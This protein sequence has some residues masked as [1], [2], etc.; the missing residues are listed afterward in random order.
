M[1][2]GTPRLPG[3]G[4][5]R[6]PA[7]AA[8]GHDPAQPPPRPRQQLDLDE[9]LEAAIAIADADGLAAVSTRAVAARFDKTAMAL[10]PYVGT[11]EN[12]LAL[13]RDHASAMPAWEDPGTEPGRRAAGLGAGAVRGVPGPPVARPNGHGHRRARARTSRTGSNG[14]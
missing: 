5:A 11:K 3:R 8:P 14:C 10:Y 4:R 9:I 1:D 6:P 2:Y 7:L 13:M 12:L